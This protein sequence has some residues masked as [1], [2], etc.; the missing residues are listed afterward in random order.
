[1]I[2]FI[3]FKFHFKYIYMKFTHQLS[4]VL[5]AAILF[6]ACK[7][8]NDDDAAP[9]KSKKEI[10]ITGK[11]KATGFV[12]VTDT[13][14]KTSTEDWFK[15][16]EPCEKDNF[17]TFNSDGT[18]TND[19]GPLKCDPG[20]PQT[21]SGGTWELM[22]NDAQMK[23]VDG[24]DIQTADVIELNDNTFKLSMKETLSNGTLTLTATY[25]HIK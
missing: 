11:W 5:I 13:A 17:L 10:L 2:F 7:P 19:E 14:G 16:M 6:A 4:I 23:L 12:A 8:N 24:T 18:V 1:M 3:I 25:T 20:D 22:N 15:D 9:A 21:Y